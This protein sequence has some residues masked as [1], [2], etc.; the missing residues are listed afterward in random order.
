MSETVSLDQVRKMEAAQVQRPA[1]GDT[2]TLDQVRRLAPPTPPPASANFSQLPPWAEPVKRGLDSAQAWPFVG[3][4]IR[5]LRDRG[6]AIGQA[7]IHPFASAETSRNYELMRQDSERK[8]QESRHAAGDEGVDWDRLL[9][10]AV[11]DAYVTSKIPGLRAAAPTLLGRAGQGAAFGAVSGA[12]SPTENADSKSGFLGQK[13]TQVGGGALIGGAAPFVIEPAIAGVTAAANKVAS[14]IAGAAKGAVKSISDDS[15]ALNLQLTLKQQGIDWSSL[16]DEVKRSMVADVRK[17]VANNKPITPE[18][19]ARATDFRALGTQPTRGQLTLDPMLVKQEQNL[20]GTDSIGKPLTELFD[21]QNKAIFDR[22]GLLR[23][24]TGGSASDI[25]DAGQSVIASMSKR[26]DAAKKSVSAMY[27]LAKQAAGRDAEVPLT[28]LAQKYG[29]MRGY[30][31]DDLLPGAVRKRLLDLGLIDGTQRRLFTINEAEDLIKAINR[32][33][34]PSKQA[35]ARALDEIRRAVNE[36]VEAL[37]DGI[38]PAAALAR[39]ARKAASERFGS[40]EATPALDALIQ[41]KLR[42]DDFIEKYVVSKSASLE[43]IQNLLKHVDPEAK[44]NIKAA[45]VNHLT[46]RAAGKSPKGAEQFNYGAFAE[47]VERIGPRKL[48]EIFTPD[49]VADIERIVRV[50]AAMNFSPKSVTINRSGTSQAFIDLAMRMNK[51][52]WINKIVASPIET[53]AG[54]WQVGS[55]MNPSLSGVPGGLLSDALRRQLAETGG[56]LGAAALGPV[57]A[58]LLTQ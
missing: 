36:G 47:E 15:I 53:A 29:E 2:L 33:Y 52:P 5:A 24:K 7:A 58:G 57:P 13:A 16:G 8:Y 35:Q 6:E 11:F 30:I 25:Y 48:R 56:L 23:E 4:S 28:P 20:K 3:G 34:D 51:L 9:A 21:E 55:A 27:D 50:G 43:D 10:G 17:A 31:D 38:G 41:G 18:Q 46:K 19:I 1:S 49:E 44:A 26:D 39:Q 37:G 54:S 32:N 22:L 14:R 45:V 42:P 12:L 40:I